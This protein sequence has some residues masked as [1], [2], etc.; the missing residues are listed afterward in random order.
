L[1]IAASPNPKAA[2]NPSNYCINCKEATQ[3]EVATMEAMGEATMEGTEE[4]ITM[5]PTGLHST[6]VFPANILNII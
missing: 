1:K 6:F 5:D 3:M 2:I 4:E